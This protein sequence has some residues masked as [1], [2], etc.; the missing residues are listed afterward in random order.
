MALSR[1]RSTN[2]CEAAPSINIAVDPIVGRAPLSMSRVY[3]FRAKAAAQPRIFNKHCRCTWR[4]SEDLEAPAGGG[5]DAPSWRV[6][7]CAR[8]WMAGSRP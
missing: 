8:P 3:G 1:A 6:M 4:D 5:M 7:W 2:P